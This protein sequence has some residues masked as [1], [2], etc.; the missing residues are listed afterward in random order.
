MSRTDRGFC[1]F[2]CDYET[3]KRRLNVALSHLT[4]A[5]KIMRALLDEVNQIQEKLYNV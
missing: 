4:E 3:L 2:K 1:A 5:E